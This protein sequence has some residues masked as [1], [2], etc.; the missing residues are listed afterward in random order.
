ML[1]SFWVD[2]ARQRLEGA[3]EVG[4]ATLPDVFGSNAALIPTRMKNA[5]VTPIAT[6][7]EKRIHT[8]ERP[9]VQSAR[10]IRRFLFMAALS[11]SC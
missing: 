5:T 1:S 10:T 6:F 11:F 7:R 4:V 3:P 8:S 9:R 2:T